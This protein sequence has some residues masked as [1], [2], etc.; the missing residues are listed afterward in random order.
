MLC[1][2]VTQVTLAGSQVEIYLIVKI[3]KIGSNVKLP[4]LVP[5]IESARQNGGQ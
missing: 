2:V 4:Q 1:K 5:A 3:R